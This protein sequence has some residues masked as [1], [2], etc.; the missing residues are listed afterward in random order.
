MKKI[1]GFYAYYQVFK[2]HRGSDQLIIAEKIQQLIKR[3]ENEINLS[4][5]DRNYKFKIFFDVVRKEQLTLDHFKSFLAKHPE[6]TIICQVPNYFPKT[7]LP[8]EL[9][10]LIC[11]DSFRILPEEAQSNSFKTP[12]SSGPKQEL[13][14]VKSIL[15][16]QK[17]NLIMPF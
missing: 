3:L 11:F 12:L 5:R 13:V 14:I 15:K 2:D 6:I 1:I 8:D 10:Q 9:K 4:V 7:Q 16:T 17:S